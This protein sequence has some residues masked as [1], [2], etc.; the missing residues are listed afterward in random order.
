MKKVFNNNVLLAETDQLQEV[1]LMGKGVGYGLKLNDTPDETKIEKKF[2][3][4]SKDIENLF[5]DMINDIP[6]SYLDLTKRIVE[7]AEETLNTTFNASIFIGLADHINYAI[8][9]AKSDQKFTNALLWEIKKFYKK[10]FDVAMECIKMIEYHEQVELPEDEAGFIAMHLINENQESEGVKD[11]VV[12]TKVIQDILT[13]VKYHFKIDLD[14]NSVNYS[15]FITHIRFFLHRTK[16]LVEG[17]DDFLFRQVRKRY[18]DTFDCA[19]K[20]RKYFENSMQIKLSN[21]EL[22][23][24]MLHVQR[25]TERDGR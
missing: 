24:F 17:E 10:E 1:I 21:E 4:D 8:T 12:T 16:N 18:P 3:L 19:L 14:E 25:L 13:I 23:Y 20:I 7:H 11:A 15:R 6:A 22:L 9:R 2:V 5:L